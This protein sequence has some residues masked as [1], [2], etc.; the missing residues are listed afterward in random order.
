MML[1]AR[2]H[3]ETRRKTYGREFSEERNGLWRRDKLCDSVIAIIHEQ[4]NNAFCLGWD[5]NYP[6]GSG[7]NYVNEWN[8]VVLYNVFGL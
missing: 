6:G 8:G 4:G 7:A 5:G 2:W 1:D 3:I